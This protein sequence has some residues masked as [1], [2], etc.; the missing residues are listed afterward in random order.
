MVKASSWTT[1]PFTRS[2]EAYFGGGGSRHYGGARGGSCRGE[3]KTLG[4][5]FGP[6]V[7]EE[8][9]SRGV[10]APHRRCLGCG[11]RAG[12]HSSWSVASGGGG[13]SFCIPF[14]TE[15]RRG[16]SR[17][18]RGGRGREG[19]RQASEA[20]ADDG[21]AVGWPTRFFWHSH[22]SKPKAC[23]SASWSEGSAKG[24]FKD[25]NRVQC[26]GSHGGSISSRGRYTSGA[27]G[28]LGGLV[29]EDQQNAGFASASS[30][31]EEVRFERI[32]GRRKRRGRRERRRCRGRE[33][34]GPARW[35][36]GEGSHAVDKDC[37]FAGKEA[38]QEEGLGG[39]FG[40]S[41]HRRLIYLDEL[42]QVQSSSLQ[43]VEERSGKQAR[44]FGQHVG[45]GHGRRLP[46]AASRAGVR[47]E[48]YLSSS[49]AGASLQTAV[50]PGVNS[51]GLDSGGDL[52]LLGKWQ[53]GR[54]KGPLP[55]GGCGSGSSL[56][57]R[58]KL[59]D[60]TGDAARTS[61]TVRCFSRPSIA[62]GLGAD[63]DQVGGRALGRNSYVEVEGQGQFQRGPQAS[64]HWEESQCSSSHQ[65]WPDCRPEPQERRKRRQRRKAGAAEG[66]FGGRRKGLKREEKGDLPSPE[67]DEAEVPGAKASVVH[68]SRIWTMV[69][70]IVCRARTKLG[71]AFFSAKTSPARQRA[72]AGKVWP[73]PLPF[74]ELHQ[75]KANRHQVDAARK[76]ALNYVVLVMDVFHNGQS[77]FARA[78][79]GLGTP[80]NKEQW[81]MIRRWTP[82]IDEWNNSCHI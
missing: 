42:I 12:A 63:S 16:R 67:K 14:R 1:V 82:L 29:E 70:D 27:V 72:P 23:E 22:G 43:E 44:G 32:R 48:G 37:E 52:R 57:R 30:N 28:R 46:S 66:S 55:F 45:G 74:P 17:A 3:Y 69:F 54:S 71:L 24:V 47:S 26:V 73:C 81:E 36:R 78:V 9:E 2:S 58:G 31:E 68:A 10:Y 53:S 56:L 34:S 76:L 35:S 75:R 4:W 50:L 21:E 19:W 51:S 41:V 80:L 39:V 11:V 61:S 49:L 60:G 62:G 5:P 77:H 40:R 59:A 64:Q 13:R 15:W 65:G 38:R 18:C 6:K 25:G 20:G 8:V 7:G 33:G 79:P